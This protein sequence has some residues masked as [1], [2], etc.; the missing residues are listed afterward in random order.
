[1]KWDRNSTRHAARCLCLAI[2]LE[3]YPSILLGTKEASGWFS[4]HC[5]GAS[6][7]LVNVDGLPRKQKLNM[8]MRHYA[9]PWEAYR[10]QETWED[11]HAERCLS[12]GKCE[13]ATSARIWLDKCE[14]SDKRISGKYDVNFGEEHLEGTFHLKYRKQE[15]I[16]M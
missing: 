12:A 5:D 9:L 7:F 4:P 16:C 14:P 13:N 15:W 3:L 11:V 1:M 10:P 6:F 2:L 8:T